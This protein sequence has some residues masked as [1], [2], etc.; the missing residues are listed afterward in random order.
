MLPLERA[1][2]E[3]AEKILKETRGRHPRGA[4]PATRMKHRVAAAKREVSYFAARAASRAAAGERGAGGE[5][6]TSNFDRRSNPL[7][8]SRSRSVSSAGKMRDAPV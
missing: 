6:A 4:R 5:G 8:A 2:L 3:R 1:L 7:A